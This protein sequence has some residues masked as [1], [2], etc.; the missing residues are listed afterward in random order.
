[1]QDLT[2]CENYRVNTAKHHITCHFNYSISF[3]H[4]RAIESMP[5]IIFAPLFQVVGL[6]FFFA[7]C[8]FYAFNVATNYIAF[9]EEKQ[10]QQLSNRYGAIMYLWRVL[11]FQQ[12][13][14]SHE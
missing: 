3:Y 8:L 10:V 14:C 7:P 6:F 12:C 2:V 4:I 9:A 13:Q 5:F 1:M 11:L